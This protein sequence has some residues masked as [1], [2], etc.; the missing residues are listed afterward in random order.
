MSFA[1]DAL[2]RTGVGQTKQSRCIGND[3][4]FLVSLAALIS[5]AMIFLT[6]CTPGFIIFNAFLE[7]VLACASWAAFCNGSASESCEPEVLA[8]VTAS[9]GRVELINQVTLIVDAKDI[10]KLNNVWSKDEQYG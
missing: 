2:Y 5:G 9:W 3:N 8:F 6:V 1:H 10:W 4:C 7:A